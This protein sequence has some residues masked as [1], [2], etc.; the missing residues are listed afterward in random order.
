MAHMR[1]NCMRQ[2]LPLAMGGRAGTVPPDTPPARSLTVGEKGK[3]S[4]KQ[5]RAGLSLSP[6]REGEGW[7][8]GRNGG[9]AELRPN[10]HA[11]LG[12]Q[13]PSDTGHSNEPTS[14]GDPGYL[15]ALGHLAIDSAAGS[16]G[17][18]SPMASTRFGFSSRTKGR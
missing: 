6:R 3:A 4:L 11:R 18:C 5:A 2:T 12:E 9:T 15:A 17:R 7:G 16:D 8:E 10:A 13:Q 14:S 1:E